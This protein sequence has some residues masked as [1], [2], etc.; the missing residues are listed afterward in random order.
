MITL[1]FIAKYDKKIHYVWFGGKPLPQPVLS[2]IRSWQ[3]YCPDWEIIQWNETNFPINEYRWVKEAIENKRYAFAAD[4]VRLYVL[5]TIGGAYCDTD[6][7]ILRPIERSI[8]GLFVSAIENGRFGTNLLENVTEDGYMK[9]TNEY[10][11]WFKLQCGFMYAEPNHPY[12]INCLNNIYNG[13]GKKFANEDGTD[14]SFVIDVSMM[15]E[16][17]KWNIKFIDKTQRLKDD[18]LIYDSSVYATRK[19]RNNNS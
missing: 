5:K 16:L 10:C 14:N 17:R 13:G 9:D 15:N 4:F 1:T 19:S 18:I 2:C 6:V 3:K 7:E 11:T 8:N 12:I